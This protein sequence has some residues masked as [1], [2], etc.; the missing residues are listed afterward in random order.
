MSQVLSFSGVSSTEKV[1]MPSGVKENVVGGAENYLGPIRTGSDNCR[2]A[3]DQAGTQSPPGYSRVG[4]GCCK[5]Y[6]SRSAWLYG[7]FSII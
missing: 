1:G 4:G 5:S 6:P 2:K 7:Y 3:V